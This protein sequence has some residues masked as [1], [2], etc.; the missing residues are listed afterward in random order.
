MNIRKEK[1]ELRNRI[2]EK[3]AALSEQ[4]KAEA[5]RIIT[6]RLLLLPEYL[7][8]ERVFAFVG[9]ENEINTKLF[10]EQVLADGKLLAVPLCVGKG[11]MEAK[12]IRS[13]SELKR[14]AY[15]ILEPEASAETVLL[16]EEDLAV[17][18][19]LSC[20]HKGNRLGHGAGFYDRYFQEL[21][22]REVIICREAL[23]EENI[24]M[25]ETD[26]KF[27]KVLT[28]KGLYSESLKDSK[29]KDSN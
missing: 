5:D 16:K 27:A 3:T 24:P 21:R 6:E 14:G 10:L 7:K 25:E 20:D 9:T 26:H 1:R 23:V 29:K 18:P 8:A 22:T 19:C 28:E 17:I 11:I 13:L 12:R 15:D 4:Y 2:R